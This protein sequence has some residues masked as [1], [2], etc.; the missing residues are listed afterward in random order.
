MRRC[1]FCASVYS[2]QEL[3]SVIFPVSI[4]NENQH[5]EIAEASWK[6]FTD[7]NEVS[8]KRLPIQ[9]FGIFFCELPREILVDKALMLVISD[10]ESGDWL[11]LLP[12]LARSWTRNPYEAP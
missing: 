5:L 3:A 9:R 12:T 8:L 7:S 4:V 1:D 11:F 10:K 6:T 2:V